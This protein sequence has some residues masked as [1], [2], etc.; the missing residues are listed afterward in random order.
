MNLNEY[1]IKASKGIKKRFDKKKKENEALY[2]SF[3]VKEPEIIK[4][5]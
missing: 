2:N 1:L 5:N 4:S 3:E